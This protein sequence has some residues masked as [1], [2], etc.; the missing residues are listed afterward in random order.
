MTDRTGRS[1]APGRGR[2]G[3]GRPGVGKPV[4]TST[5]SLQTVA[6]A[7]QE[8]RGAAHPNPPY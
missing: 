8:I 1:T 7:T 3:R 2:E 4:Q 5:P 6:A